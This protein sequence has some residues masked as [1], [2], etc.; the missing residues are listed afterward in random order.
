MDK[1]DN[2]YIFKDTMRRIKE[3]V[4]LSSAVCDSINKEKLIL[5]GGE[6]IPSFNITY[7]VDARIIVSR[8]RT[9]EAAVA[10]KGMKTA[11]LNFAS[12]VSPGGGVTGGSFAQEESLCRSSTLY[13]CLKTEYL[14]D[15]YYTPHRNGFD[16]RNTDDTI[17]TP[18]VIVF[19]QDE[20]YPVALDE[21]YWFPV[22]VITT[23]APDLKL[24]RYT[25]EKGCVTLSD[26]ELTALHMKRAERI[27]SIAAGEGN[28]VVI[29]GAFG[30]GAFHNP[31]RLVAEAFKKVIEK[32]FLDKFKVIEFAVY[33]NPFGEGSENADVFSSVFNVEIPFHRY[34]EAF[35]N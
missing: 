16:R 17:Y 20:L 1:R 7:P 5:E 3:S 31:P 21:K 22:N 24:P 26:D 10:Y 25:S 29:L 2:K 13:P 12:A 14:W 28:E 11:V 6:Y 27:L 8:K 15:N 32:S 9:Y 19:K 18:D 34:K 30:C 23:A 35:D 4:T 33:T